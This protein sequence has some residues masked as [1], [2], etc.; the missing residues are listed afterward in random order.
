MSKKRKKVTSK[1]PLSKTGKN[2]KPKK[3]AKKSKVSHKAGKKNPSKTRKRVTSSNRL[4]KNKRKKNVQQK[5]RVRK[6]KL[7]KKVLVKRK[8]QPNK[9]QRT[10]KSRKGVK[11]K[12]K[13]TQKQ[14]PRND[15][16]FKAVKSTRGSI[17][18]IDFSFSKVRKVDKKISLFKDYAGESIG[19]QLRTKKGKPPKGI[20]VTVRD[21]SGR[22]KTELSRFDFVVNKESTQK[23]VGD[24]LGR[25]KD[26][27]MEWVEMD[28]SGDVPDGDANPYGDYNP[29]TISNI[30]IKFIY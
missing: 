23:F 12:V 11:Q 10:G 5:N 3:H 30:T 2:T 20:I 13:P 24:M 15:G 4:P 8:V 1:K 16:K 25:M 19:K 6:S 27:F 21:K 26:D 29:D 28:E 22:E 17:P 18:Q 7:V 9:K 14:A